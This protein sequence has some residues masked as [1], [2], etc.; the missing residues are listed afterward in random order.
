[1]NRSLLINVGL[2]LV[3]MVVAFFLLRDGLQHESNV[4]SGQQTNNKL[5]EL[6]D[7]KETCVRDAG[8]HLVPVAAYKRIISLS[9]TVDAF[10]LQTVGIG[11]VRAYCSYSKSKPYAADL[12]DLQSF[13]DAKNIEALIQAEGDL[14]IIPSMGGDLSVVNRLREA[15][16]TVFNIGDMSGLESF[17]RYGRQLAHLCAVP[18]AGDALIGQ[19]R[20]KINGIAKDLPKENRKSALYVSVFN[21]QCYGG[22]K[23]SAYHDIIIAAG[24]TD[25]AN[26]ATWEWSSAWPQLSVEQI[27]QLNPDILIMPKGARD[28]VT[29]VAGLDALP[30]VKHGRIYEVDPVYMHDAG[31]LM[32]EAACT[33][34]NLVY[35]GTP[36]K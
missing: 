27:L 12:K 30:A 2:F 22:I 1:M 17:S 10:L 21:D 29:S 32:Y 36:V 31:L 11:R 35:K 15:G 20:T 14:I 5:L 24:L 3:A 13:P 34:F 8:G 33:I 25:A 16:L 4:E 7:K 26:K 19:F 6:N 18:V 23:G 9:T 28:S